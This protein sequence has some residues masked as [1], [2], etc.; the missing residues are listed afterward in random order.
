MELDLPFFDYVARRYEG[1]VTEELSAY[2]A[3]R[4]ERFKVSLTEHFY[5]NRDKE[6]QH[7][8]LLMIGTDRKFK[9]MKMAVDENNLEVL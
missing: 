7:L 9:F 6:D 2:Y 5:T 4:L 3:D 1:E 8:R